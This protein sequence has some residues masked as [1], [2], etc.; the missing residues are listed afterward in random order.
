[1]ALF[2]LY[3]PKLQESG[4]LEEK[5]LCGVAASRCGAM[6]CGLLKKIPNRP[7][8]T[9]VE[10]NVRQIGRAFVMESYHA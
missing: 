2:G 3:R 10:S 8:W 9:C 5:A 4:H 1:M 6:T 7:R